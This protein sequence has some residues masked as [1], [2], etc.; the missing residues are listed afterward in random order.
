MT[1]TE[2]VRQ[3]LE[4]CGRASTDQMRTDLELSSEVVAG[5]VAELVARD[6]IRREARGLY[7]WRGRNPAPGEVERRIWQAM[8][9]NPVWSIQE[10]AM[11]AG[12]STHYV[13]KRLRG[14][15][16][17]GFARQSGRRN[18]FGCGSE[19]LYR[20]TG[21]GQQRLAPPDTERHEPDPLIKC[22]VELNRLICT[23]RIHHSVNDFAEAVRLCVILQTS[24]EKLQQEESENAE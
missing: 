3:Y 4:A 22:A 13:R 7:V 21:R 10:V 24:L 2:R 23:G 9:I 5:V 17:E 16:A 18:T 19:K 14:Y 11:Q 6:E 12:T 8:R 20:L 15:L 1:T